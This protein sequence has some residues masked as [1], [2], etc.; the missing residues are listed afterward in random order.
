MNPPVRS[1]L[2]VRQRIQVA[3]GAAAVL[4]AISLSPGDAKAAC[5]LNSPANTCRVTVESVEYDVTT[6]V[7]S[8]NSNMAEFANLPTP[9]VMPWWGSEQTASAFAIAVG[10]AF[11]SPN[12]FAETYGPFFAFR[13]NDLFCRVLDALYPSPLIPLAPISKSLALATQLRGWFWGIAT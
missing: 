5:A 11:G 10:T 3:L 8:Y 9:G 12:V 4:A 6:F 7:G 1:S 13:T 2:L